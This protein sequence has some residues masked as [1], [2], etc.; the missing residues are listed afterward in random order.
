MYLKFVCLK[1]KKHYYE[2]RNS[3][4]KLLTHPAITTHIWKPLR[5]KTLLFVQPPSCSD[6]KFRKSHTVTVTGKANQTQ[7]N[8]SKNISKKC[9]FHCK[10]SLML[11]NVK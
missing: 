6:E 11:Y 9:N 3:N 8:D 4:S 7:L 1:G 10:N 2:R 5:I